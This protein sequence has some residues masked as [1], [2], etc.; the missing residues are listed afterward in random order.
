MAIHPSWLV[1]LT[2]SHLSQVNATQ[3][4]HY[5]DALYWSTLTAQVHCQRAKVKLGRAE[6]GVELQIMSAADQRCRLAAVASWLRSSQ[7]RKGEKITVFV[8]F[9]NH[10][11]GGGA[12]K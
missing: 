6:N 2:A 11:S 10:G 12:K 1:V 9:W 4:I 5:D 7:S 3:I 8:L